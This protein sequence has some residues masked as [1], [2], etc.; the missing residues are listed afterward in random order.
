MP[1]ER[2]SQIPPSKGRVQNELLKFKSGGPSVEEARA[3]MVEAAEAATTKGR[4]T[5][6]PEFILKAQRQGGNTPANRPDSAKEAF[7]QSALQKWTHIVVRDF[8]LI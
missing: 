6:V 7:V 1:V 8:R 5:K 4:G 3:A 2:V